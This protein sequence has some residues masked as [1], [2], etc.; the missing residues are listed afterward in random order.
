VTDDYYLRPNLLG[1][2]YTDEIILRLKKKEIAMENV[3]GKALLD[4]GRSV[5]Q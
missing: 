3:N 4:F 5:I 2:L 1:T